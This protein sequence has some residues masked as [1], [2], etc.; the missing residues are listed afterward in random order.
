M[1]ET[2]ETMLGVAAVLVAACYV[3][4]AVVFVT[5][6]IIALFRWRE[7]AAFIE[8]ITKDKQQGDGF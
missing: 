5:A 7:V 2:V 1:G 4:F 8:R 6:I 3:L